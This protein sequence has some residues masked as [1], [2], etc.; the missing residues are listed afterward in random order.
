MKRKKIVILGTLIVVVSMVMLL[1]PLNALFARP[2]SC[3][4]CIKEDPAGNLLAGTGF[5]LYHSSGN[6][7]VPERFTDDSGMITFC[8]LPDDTYTVRE[9]TA[10]AGFGT[11]PDQTATLN[12]ENLRVTLNFVDDPITRNTGG[13][14]TTTTGG[15]ET[16]PPE[17]ITVLGVTEELPFTGQSMWLY[18][19]GAAMLALAGGLTFVL[20]AVKSKA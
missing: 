1:L 7:A 14:T 8:G 10:P 13:R 12:S 18:I 3:I 20:R 6:Q 19:I 9:T 2:L 17:E 11:A 5:T 16:P 4:T 15:G